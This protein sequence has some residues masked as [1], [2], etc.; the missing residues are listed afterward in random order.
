M[1]GPRG[2]IVALLL[3]LCGLALAWGTSSVNAAHAK[4]NPDAFSASLTG[5]TV[6][7]NM[8]G[9][10]PD[11]DAINRVIIVTHVQIHHA[12]PAGIHWP[13]IHMTLILDAYLES[14]QTDTQPVLPDLIHPK[15]SVSASLGG[16]FSG[17]AILVGPSNRIL[18]RGSMLA[19]ALIAPICMYSTAS[20]SPK[21]CRVETQHMIINLVGQGPAKGGFMNLDS[22]FLGNSKLQVPS[23]TL[24]GSAV[25][26]TKAR[27]LM[28]RPAGT[29]GI[30]QV[31][32]D[33]HVPLPPMRGT[34][35]TGATGRTKGYCFH[36]H[37]TNQGSNP[38][39]DPPVST[40][41][42]SARPAW[43]APLGGALIGFAIILLAIYFWQQRKQL[44][45]SA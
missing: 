20:N 32:N 3:T 14:F 40:T 37:C 27:A 4:R 26:P 31:L 18:Y 23:G 1:M 30:E 45:P 5:K 44:P 8:A 15:I 12:R 24:Y 16:F 35:A 43:M 38:T 13:R 39:Q 10:E 6:Y 11:F 19:E 2:R 28:Q 7:F 42:T 22:S 33:F 34:A 9:Q 36:G 29:L 21:E 25:I 17:E 41:T